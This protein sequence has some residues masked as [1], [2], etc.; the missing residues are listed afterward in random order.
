MSL[1]SILGGGV[2]EWLSG[3]GPESDIV[4]STRIRLAR[5]LAAYRFL[6]TIAP[7]RRRE[8]A[9][10]I[11]R[12]FREGGL[13]DSVGYYDLETVSSLDRRC[14]VE[15][16]LISKDLE[17]ASGERGVAIDDNETLSIMVNEEDHL[18]IQVLR[19]GFQ[20][21]TAWDQISQVDDRLEDR[22]DFAF[23]QRFGYLTSC[24]TNAGTGLRISVMLHLPA[25]VLSKTMPK[26]VKAMNK[27][28]LVVRG[29]YGEGTH[30][31]GDFFQI[32]NQITL[33]KAESALLKQIEDHVPQIIRH[34]RSMRE[35]LI[36]QNRLGLEDRIW[37]ALGMLER[38]RMITS[39]ETMDCLS[40]VR[41]GINLGLLDRL[42]LA[43]VNELFIITQPAHLQKLEGRELESTER[44]ERR[45]SLIRERLAAGMA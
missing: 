9:E 34:E 31:H 13:P 22:L 42:P 35:R 45:A 43:L 14:L 11:E 5:N 25:L 17:K 27:V 28:K 7:G 33:G 29:F 2:G 3:G 32:S 20:L 6:T 23:S 15:R 30:P 38:A 19:S 44:D 37:R 39:E 40:A 24:P 16:H 26:V 36:E 12:R 18:R 41:M 21:A 8:L 1:E 4:M 10:T